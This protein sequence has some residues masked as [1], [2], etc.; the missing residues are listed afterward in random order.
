MS[1]QNSYNDKLIS[2]EKAASMIQSGDKIWGGGFLS[3][4]VLFFQELNKVALELKNTTL[5]SGLFTYPYE[6]LK[7]EYI[8]HLDYKSL[9]MGPLEKKFQQKGNAQII[10]YHLSNVDEVLLKQNFNVMVIETTP[11][12]EE[13]YMSLGACGGMGNRFIM[14]N[15]DTM[16]L[17][18]TVCNDQQPFVGNPENLIH[19]S[20]VNYLT[21]GHHSIATSKPDKPSEVE[22]KIANHIK[23]LIKDGSTIQIG[24]GTLSDAVGVGLKDHQ[25]LGIHTEMF[26]ESMMELCKAGVV[27]GS[28]KNYQPNRV[29][30][31][32]SAG[33]QELMDFLHNGD[34]VEIG[35]VTVVNKPVEIAKNDN[36]ISIN[37]CIMVD[38]TGQVAS[39]GVGH[40]QISGSG[41]Q[42][43]FVRGARMSKGGLSIIALASTY[44][45]P[46]GMESTIKLAL[47]EGTPVTTP[48]ND[49]Q[50]IAT[51]Y[52]IA[53][54]RGLSTVERAEAMINIA[55]PELRQ[56]LRDTAKQIGRIR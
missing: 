17:I 24:I 47:P 44:Q 10:P 31:A 20:E 45:A 32:F 6:F 23:P 25:N 50:L 51:E 42:V 19:V 43:D 41:G 34:N 1:W 11:P 7:P 3:V 4:P 35:D 39:E 37:T 38:L 49:V 26:T 8:G 40:T 48:R 55:H 56:E 21:E 16:Q 30:T 14:Q 9:F 5:Y 46:T 2:N 12:N 22:T 13:G 33:S 29:V 52:G 54:L 18:I 15:V 36:L 28:K 53:D 27:N